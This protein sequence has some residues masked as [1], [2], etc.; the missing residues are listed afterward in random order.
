MAQQ[1]GT[2]VVYPKGG[3]SRNPVPSV[4]PKPLQEDYNEACLV[5]A[6][7]P[8]ASAALS[9]RCLQTILRDHARVKPQNLN[10]EIDEVVASNTLPTHLSNDLHAIRAV[11]NFAAHPTKD[12][13]TGEIVAVEPGEAEWLLDLL[14]GLF[15]FYFVAPAETQR[16]RD[17]LNAKPGAPSFAFFAKGGIPDCRPLR[18]SDRDS[19]G[20]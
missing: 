2:H 6:D 3:T 14:E 1:L 7:S 17:E 20:V 13:S 5:L 10:K 8:K 16:R 4:V 11:G 15:D 19:N 18:I 12:T 9:R